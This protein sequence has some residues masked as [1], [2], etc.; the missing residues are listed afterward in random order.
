MKKL[1]FAS[2]FAVSMTSSVVLADDVEKMIESKMGEIKETTEN[3]IS[4]IEE[5]NPRAAME[6]LEWLKNLIAPIDIEI[7][8]SILFTDA[9]GDFK[10][11][12]Q[13]TYESAMSITTIK[14]AYKSGGDKIQMQLMS[15]GAASNNPFANIAAMQQKYGQQQDQVRLGRRVMAN[16]VDQGGNAKLTAS[17]EN[18]TLELSGA[19]KDRIVSF[20]NELAVRDFEK[21]TAKK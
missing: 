12:D 10:A 14:R 21:Y 1:L 17:I 16:V 19:S 3:L 7:I 11:V 9:V 2:L 4:Y 18:Y 15:I 13:A 8:K 5:G 6:E 20:A